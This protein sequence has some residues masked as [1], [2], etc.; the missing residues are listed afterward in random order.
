[1]NILRMFVSKS[2]NF[3]SSTQELA[4]IQKRFTIFNNDDDDN[5][6]SEIKVKINKFDIY[7]E[8]RDELNEWLMQIDVHLT[9]NQVSI[10][11]QTLFAFIFFKERA[12][13]W[14]KS[15]FKKYLDNEKNENEIF[16]RY[17]K[18]KQKI[19]RIFEIV[20]E[21]FIAKRIVQHFTQ[22]ISTIEYAIKFQ[23]QINFTNWDDFSLM[24]IYRKKFKNDIKNELMRYDDEISNMNQ[25]IATSI[26]LNDKLYERFLKK[27]NLDFHERFNI[28][29]NYEKNYRIEKSRFNKRN[30]INYSKSNYYESM[31]MKLNFTQRRKEKNSKKNKIIKTRR[32]IHVTR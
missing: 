22:K 31:S 14:L 25:L 12:K 19:R 26:D 18:F 27:R 9:F 15:K 21:K 32:V 5:D 28:Y 3:I 10:D 8:D 30:N 2:R 20:N 11:K 13:R 16:K 23:K 1:M 17:L 24:I 4:T 29:E 7:H 6:K